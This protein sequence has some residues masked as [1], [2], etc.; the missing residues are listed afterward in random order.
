MNGYVLLGFAIFA[1]VIA[2]TSLKALDGFNKPVPL[3][4]VVVGYSIALY[5]LSLV[6]KTVP[7][8]VAYGTWAGLGI[9]IVSVAAYFIY[10]Q[11]LDMPAILGMS[12]IVLGVFITQLFS[13]TAGH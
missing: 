6:V 4:L 8:G 7:V 9:V 12:L 10:K 3:F 11:K 2:T 1:E 13:K 5:L